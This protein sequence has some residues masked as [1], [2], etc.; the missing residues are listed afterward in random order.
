LV[1]QRISTGEYVAVITGTT[2]L[3]EEDDHEIAF[4]APSSV[5]VSGSTISIVSPFN[6]HL[7][8]VRGQALE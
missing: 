4:E 8:G 2:N 5:T 1:F 6:P 3:C 7:C